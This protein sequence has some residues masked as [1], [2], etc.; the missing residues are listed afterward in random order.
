MRQNKARKIIDL[1]KRKM[2]KVKSIREL[3]ESEF[4][5][6][7]KSGLLKTIYPQAPDEFEQIR[8][9]RPKPIY[10]PDFAPLIE[11]CEKYMEMVKNPEHMLKDPEHYIYEI[12]V[13]CVYGKNKDS[14]VR[15]FIN[16]NT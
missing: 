12:A 9:R 11:Y 8:G 14:G 7:K 10:S 15:D 16:K 5:K 2:E 1:K 4:N 6:L 3:T 13:N